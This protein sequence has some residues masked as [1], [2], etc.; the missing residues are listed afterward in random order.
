MGYSVLFAPNVERAVQ[1][2][3]IFHDLVR[4]VI[5]HPEQVKQCWGHDACLRTQDNP[6]GIPVWKI[7]AFHFWPGA[8]TPLGTKWTLSP[9]DVRT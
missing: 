8:A 7:F 3:H 6:A 5:M 4:V 9:E 1:L 2:Y